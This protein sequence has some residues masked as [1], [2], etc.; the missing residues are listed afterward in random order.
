MKL[1]TLFLAASRITRAMEKANQQRE[2]L[3]RKLE[4]KNVFEEESH[5]REQKKRDKEILEIMAKPYKVN[6]VRFSDFEDAITFACLAGGAII[7]DD[8]NHKRQYCKM[9]DDSIVLSEVE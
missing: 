6:T 7:I 5:L 9:V 4:R 8:I 2:R 1:H 3:E